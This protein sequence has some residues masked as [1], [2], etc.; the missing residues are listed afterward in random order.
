[1]KLSGKLNPLFWAVGVMIY[2]IVVSIPW[3]TSEASLPALAPFFS[4]SQGFWQNAEIVRPFHSEEITLSVNEQV[5]VVFDEIG[6]PH[7]FAESIED[8]FFALGYLHA[9]DRFFQMDFTHRAAVG[10]ISDLIGSAALDYDLEMRK[11]GMGPMIENMV[12]KWEEDPEISDLLSTYIKGVNA[13]VSSL[14]KSQFPIE[15]KLLSQS[16]Q[17]WDKEKTAAI[18]GYLNHNLT[19]R[20]DDIKA[21]NTLQKVGIENYPLLFPN[22]HEDVHPVIPDE[23]LYPGLFSD[24]EALGWDEKIIPGDHPIFQQSSDWSFLSM[25]APHIGSNNWAVGPDKTTDGSTFICNDPHLPLTLPAIWYE[26]HIITPEVNLYGFSIPGVP[27]IFLGMSEHIAIATTNV[28]CDYVDWYKIHWTN[29]DRTNYTVDGEEYTVAFREEKIKSADGKNLVAQIP[30][31]LFGPM[32]YYEKSDHF[33]S[34]YSMHWRAIKPEGNLLRSLVSILRAQNFDDFLAAS[35]H[36]SDPPQNLVYGDRFGNIGL[37]ITGSLPLRAHEYD[38]VFLKDGKFK[39]S[40]FNQAIPL[41]ELPLSYNPPVGFVAS[42]NQISTGEAYPYPNVGIYDKA[43]GTHLFDRL[44]EQEAVDLEFM[45]MLLTDNRSQKAKDFL[46]TLL[47]LIN[48]EKLSREEAAVFQKLNSWNYAFEADTDEGIILK[49]WER[50]LLKT[51]WDEFQAPESDNDNKGFIRPN[52]KTTIDLLAVF[53]DLDY[54]NILTTESIEQVEDLVHFTFSQTVVKFNNWKEENP[55]GSW[56]DY[57]ASSIPHLVRIEPFS[58][59]FIQSGGTA[60]SLNSIKGSHGPSMRMIAQ[61]RDDE[62]YFYSALPGGSS[63]NPGSPFYGHRLEQ[64]EKGE[65]HQAYIG[66]DKEPIMERAS[67]TVLIAPGGN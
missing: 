30:Y 48:T 64:W 26:C 15:Y 28:G 52:W 66:R 32:P 46:E 38:G 22:R 19:F 60:S 13:S 54:W 14:S 43:R 4:P 50:E 45:K 49:K 3:K 44:Y 51:A 65:F 25:P 59:P 7:I 58:H 56:V 23:S 8:A 55:D 24:T 29:D 16:P 9:Q 67:R 10:K 37:R 53:P 5:K 41:H 12:Q 21:T 42:A 40:L 31:T 27:G 35:D 61:F 18:L 20:H 39:D 34:D 11:K 6:V 2:L 36:L 17:L 63:G 57:R 62:R 47:P 1:M 33:L